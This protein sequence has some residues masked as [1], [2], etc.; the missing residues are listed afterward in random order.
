MTDEHSPS[1][2]SMDIMIE[3]L[4]RQRRIGWAKAYAAEEQL[5]EASAALAAATGKLDALQEKVKLYHYAYRALQEVAPSLAPWL[6]GSAPGLQDF[7]GNSVCATDV[8]Q[9]L[10]E[11]GARDARSYIALDETT[12]RDRDWRARQLSEWYDDPDAALPTCAGCGC[13][14]WDHSGPA[15]PCLKCSCTVFVSG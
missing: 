5:A 13:A 11:A 12:R 2:R 8:R 1:Q 9:D 4:E 7:E 10:R 6:A 14:S 15:R 3:G